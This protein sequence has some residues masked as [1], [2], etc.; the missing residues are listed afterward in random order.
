M[1]RPRAHA[2]AMQRQDTLH[3]AQL[4]RHIASGVVFSVEIVQHNGPM[5]QRPSI[6]YD[7]AEGER[8][9]ARGRHCMKK[10]ASAG[11]WHVSR[12][13]VRFTV[14]HG[15]QT[16]RDKEGKVRTF[17]TRDAAARVARQLNTR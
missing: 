6:N 9:E 16:A 15:R 4:A 7:K 17:R 10:S 3:P 5:R 12:S 1:T 2:G 14:K 11:Q 8:D 13:G